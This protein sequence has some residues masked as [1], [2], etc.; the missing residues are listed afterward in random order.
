MSQLEK[1]KLQMWI[2]LS[3]SG[4]R[5]LISLFHYYFILTSLSKLWKWCKKFSGE[6]K[7]ERERKL[8]SWSLKL[9]IEFQL[10][11]S[12]SMKWSS[13]ASVRV[14]KVAITFSKVFFLPPSISLSSL[15]RKKGFSEE[16]SAMRVMKM[17][18]ISFMQSLALKY[19]NVFQISSHSPGFKMNFETIKST[20]KSR[21]FEW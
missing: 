16:L 5:K 2:C 6:R 13:L 11:D 17:Y 8:C 12:E 18:Q 14:G 3:Y 15:Q 1:E 4:H 19:S 9:R 21:S 10:V 7:R 20:V